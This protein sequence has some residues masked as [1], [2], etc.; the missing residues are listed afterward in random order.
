MR[1]QEVKQNSAVPRTAMNDYKPDTGG[2][3]IFLLMCAGATIEVAWAAHFG[4]G[5]GYE[6]LR[7]KSVGIG[8]CR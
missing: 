6:I 8:D 4:C 5:N 3:G 1:L 2:P 7:A